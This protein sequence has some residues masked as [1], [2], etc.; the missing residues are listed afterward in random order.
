MKK[1]L[2]LTFG[3]S[4]LL[5]VGCNA[6]QEVKKDNLNSTERSSEKSRE[7]ESVEF[8]AKGTYK[9]GEDI[10]QGDYYVVLTK[11][12]HDENDTSKLTEVDVNISDADDKYIDTVYFSS[13]GNKERVKLEEG[14]S[15]KIID[16]GIEFKDFTLSFL[17]NT[18]FKKYESES[19]NSSTA[20]NS[21]ESTINN[22]S[23][24]TETTKKIE[25]SQSVKVT[26]LL[27]DYD[28]F[29]QKIKT[30]SEKASSMSELESMN[31]V[32]DLIQ[33]QT[34][35]TSK[36]DDLKSQEL[37]DDE[38]TQLMNKSVDMLQEYTVLMN[39]LQNK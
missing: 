6:K 31:A 2:L 5:V 21:N 33:E 14:M 26:D 37:T 25:D 20:N 1:S 4:L 29:I 39:K 18:D 34:N 11:L 28:L 30:T 32:T 17:N 15:F 36:L 35:L 27:A 7:P 22:G 10:E 12:E 24:D 3:L 8:T 16:N 23:V 38:N 19:K 13:V 9:V